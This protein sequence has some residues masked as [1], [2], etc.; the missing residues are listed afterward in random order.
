MATRPRRGDGPRVLATALLAGV[1][2]LL[3]GCARSARRE[4]GQSEALQEETQQTPGGKLPAFDGLLW[5]GFYA[6]GKG[7]EPDGKQVFREVVRFLDTTTAPAELSE[8][9]VQLDTA[10]IG[11]VAKEAETLLECRSCCG[12]SG[13]NYRWGDRN[14]PE[15]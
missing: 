9:D 15:A 4:T 11:S 14:R 13:S 10:L 8:A 7:T 3:V 1:V 6:A 5:T 2:A 12:R